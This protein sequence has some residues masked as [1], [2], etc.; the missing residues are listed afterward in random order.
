VSSDVGDHMDDE[1]DDDDDD[2]YDEE[3]DVEGHNHQGL[4]VL[5]TVITI[6]L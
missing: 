2:Y 1:D 3:E 4:G 6:T 5:G